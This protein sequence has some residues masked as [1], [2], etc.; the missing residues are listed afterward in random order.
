MSRPTQRLINNLENY[1]NSLQNMYLLEV[2]QKTNKSTANRTGY[3]H[4]LTIAPP[5]YD[6]DL[7]RKSQNVGYDTAHVKHQM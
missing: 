2:L 6:L 5:V 7:F 1:L 3:A 4:H